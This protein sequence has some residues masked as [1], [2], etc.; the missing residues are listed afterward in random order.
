MA[1]ES[2]PFTMIKYAEA[3][4]RSFPFEIT[5]EGS[6]LLSKPTPTGHTL[7]ETTLFPNNLKEIM[8]NQIHVPLKE[9]H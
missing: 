1:V 9:Y 7:V 5:E 6:L 2:N 8:L 4:P 3:R